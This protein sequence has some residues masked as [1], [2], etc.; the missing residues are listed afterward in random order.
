MGAIAENRPAAHPEVQLFTG[1]LDGEAYGQALRA[2][3]LAWDIETTGLD[4]RED[5]LATV[6]LQSGELVFLVRVGER[7]PLRLKRLLERAELPKVMH[8]AMFDLRFMAYQWQATP[9]N[10]ACTKIASKLVHKD[11]SGSAHSLA[12]LVKRYFGIELDKGPRLSD[13]TAGELDAAQIRYAA[14]DV[15]FLPAL[16]DTLARELEHR[17]LL[18][19]RDRC[20][21]HLATRVE[22][23]LGGFGDVY[24]Y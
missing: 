2:P 16:H 15:R 17:D 14:D 24:D 10:V 23:E 18:G 21:D 3:L 5:R 7:V 13:W 20:Y 8:H 11:E 12:A 4:W 22:L 6:Q 1:D 9:R 19:L